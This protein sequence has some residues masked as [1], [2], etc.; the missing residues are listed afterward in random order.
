MD[1]LHVRIEF[2][3]SS[4]LQ[5]FITSFMISRDFSNGV[6]DDMY[7]KVTDKN[8]IYIQLHESGQDHFIL[9]L[10]ELR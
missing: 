4:I 2:L 10:D 3:T 6:T 5:I 9:L 8:E 7:Y 1:C